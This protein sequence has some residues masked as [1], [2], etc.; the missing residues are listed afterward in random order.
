MHIDAHFPQCYPCAMTSADLRDWRYQK[1]LTQA[2]AAKIM[3]YSL[4]Q[5]VVLENR[6]G[7][8][9]RRIELAFKAAV[10]EGANG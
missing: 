6:P 9:H 10:S 2:Q 7:D 3:G 4:R 8:L 1:R 5:Y